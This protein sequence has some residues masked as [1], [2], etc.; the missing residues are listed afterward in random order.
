M[1]KS[2]VKER[3]DIRNFKKGD[4]MFSKYYSYDFSVDDFLI[5][6]RTKLHREEIKKDW[7]IRKEYM[8]LKSLIKFEVYLSSGSRKRL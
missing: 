3:R 6:V 5:T 7:E 8:K 2:R 4:E 1:F